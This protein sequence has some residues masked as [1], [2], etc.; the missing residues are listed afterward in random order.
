MPAIDPPFDDDDVAV[1]LYTSGTTSEPKAA[2][3]RHRHLMAYLLGS[4]EFGGAGEDEA[5]LVAVPPYHVAGMANMLS[6]T[7][8]GRRLV[9]LRAFDP[10][11]WLDTVRRERITNAMVVPTMLARIV[12]AVGR[13]R[14]PT[15]RRCGRCRT[16]ARRC[17]NA[18]SS[19]RCA[20]SPTSAS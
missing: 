17:P 20:C 2:L 1:V 11:V 3:L 18:C 7:F 9:Y 16:A 6:N 19:T 10:T 15:C 8:A 12:E 13:T 5:V 14:P 4:V